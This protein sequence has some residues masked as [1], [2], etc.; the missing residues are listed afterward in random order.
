MQQ[1]EYLEA[2]LDPER[3]WWK[4]SEGRTRRLKKRSTVDVL[5][6]LGGAGWELAG[7]MPLAGAKGVSRLFFKRLLVDDAARTSN[8]NGAAT[9]E[10]I[11]VELE[12]TASA[13]SSEEAPSAP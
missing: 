3:K 13:P 4:D 5:N 10:T 7:T 2:R 9:A 6:E 12:R 8:S 1:W 11:D